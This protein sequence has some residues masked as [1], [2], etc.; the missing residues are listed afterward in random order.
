MQTIATGTTVFKVCI[1]GR[2]VAENHHAS[3]EEGPGKLP[4]TSM[5]NL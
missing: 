5:G 1:V 4:D 2:L 3:C